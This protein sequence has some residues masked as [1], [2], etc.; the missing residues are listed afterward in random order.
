MLTRHFR[1]CRFVVVAHQLVSFV[2]LCG[3]VCELGEEVG[4]EL[5]VVLGLGW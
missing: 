5:L 4:Q 1:C 2:V 3:L